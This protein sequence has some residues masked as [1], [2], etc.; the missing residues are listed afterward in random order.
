MPDDWFPYLIIKKQREREKWHSCKSWVEMI[1]TTIAIRNVANSRCMTIR[2]SSLSGEDNCF[3]TKKATCFLLLFFSLF[4][5]A[6]FPHL[7]SL[8]IIGQLT[9]RRA[10]NCIPKMAI[11]LTDSTAQ[12]ECVGCESN[13][14]VH[15]KWYSH[16][17]H[18][19]FVAISC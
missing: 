13:D 7:F 3:L 1:E 16:E 17:N 11:W 8:I 15:R 18:D 19:R 12:L 2:T 5:F 6:F 9:M 14:C 10:G 4:L